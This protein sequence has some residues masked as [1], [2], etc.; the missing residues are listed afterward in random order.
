MEY[1]KDWNRETSI[2]FASMVTGSYVWVISERILIGLIA[3]LFAHLAYTAVYQ[4]LARA[5]DLPHLSY[6]KE[7]ERDYLP[8]IMRVLPLKKL[9]RQV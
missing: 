7:F 5:L 8:R 3:G 2:L 9:T 1:F 4:A 6:V